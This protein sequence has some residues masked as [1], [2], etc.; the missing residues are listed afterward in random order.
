MIGGCTDRNLRRKQC[1]DLYNGSNSGYY[2]DGLLENRRSA[3]LF[4]RK[5]RHLLRILASL[6]GHCRPPDFHVWVAGSEQY[7]FSQFAGFTIGDRL[8]VLR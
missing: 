7:P 3:P 1:F 8:A 2:M 5:P 6:R 4:F